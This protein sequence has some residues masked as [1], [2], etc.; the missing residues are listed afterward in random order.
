[1]AKCENEDKEEEQTEIE[2][3]KRARDIVNSQM[4]KITEKGGKHRGK[5]HE[6]GK[7]CW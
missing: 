7:M 4:M 3:N 2:E 5:T 1:M 6:G